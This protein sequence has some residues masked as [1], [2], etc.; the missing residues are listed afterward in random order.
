MISC[1]LLKIYKYVTMFKQDIYHIYLYVWEELQVIISSD[2]REIYD[3]GQ[4]KAYFNQ[5]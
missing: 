3:Y 2:S 1:G 4:S 5:W